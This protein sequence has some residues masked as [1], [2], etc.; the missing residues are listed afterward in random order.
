MSKN[1]SDEQIK[2]IHSRFADL[3]KSTETADQKAI[4]QR[5][6]ARR[7]GLTFP[8]ISNLENASDDTEPSIADLL[9]YRNYFNVSVDY[10]LCLEDEPTTDVNIKALVEKY[11]LSSESLNNLER[12]ITRAESGFF[13]DPLRILNT[14]IESSQLAAFLWTLEKYLDFYSIR[15]KEYVLFDISYDEN[16]QQIIDLKSLY[17]DRVHDKEVLYITADRFEQIALDDVKELLIS[18]KKLS[19]EYL[20]KAEDDLHETQESYKNFLTYLEEYSTDHFEYPPYADHIKKEYE[21]TIAKLEKELAEGKRMKA[22]T[23]A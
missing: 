19:T 21:Q 10:L 6:L 2:A 15:K 7:T 8:R 13:G 20:K 12:L 22:I 17:L 1:F 14:I 4:S 5:E 23:H 16:K 11:G 9:A 3:R 18:I